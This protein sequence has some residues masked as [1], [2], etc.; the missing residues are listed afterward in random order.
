[1]TPSGQRINGA[2]DTRVTHYCFGKR[3]PDSADCI[4]RTDD[5]RP[6]RTE[7]RCLTLPG[8]V[9]DQQEVAVEAQQHGQTGVELSQG[10]ALYEGL[11]GGGHRG[12]GE[13]LHILTC[14]GRKQ[15]NKS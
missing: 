3:M 6:Y 9:G 1:M 15:D 14:E 2:V 13:T 12:Q 5:V 11:E 8:L 4:C 10:G 7:V